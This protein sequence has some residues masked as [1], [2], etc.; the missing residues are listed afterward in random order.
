MNVAIA[1]VYNKTLR[2][3]SNGSISNGMAMNLASND[4]ERFIMASLFISYLVWGPL[5]AIVVL[6]IGI[7]ILGPAFAFGYVLLA[8][9]FPAQ[10]YLS[11]QFATFRHKIALITD[12]RVNLLSQAVSGVRV[13]KM[14]G[15]EKSFEQKIGY[16]RRA[17]MKQ[18]QRAH[19][20][21]AMNEAIFFC[22][23]VVIATF[24]LVIHVV[25][26][27][28]EITSGK[29]FTTISLLSLIQFTM[30]KFFAFGVM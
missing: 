24:V 30:G 1:A 26:L 22:C 12:K 29:V 15:W 21:K 17:E 10:F 14:S 20:L 9:I 7:N 5:E 25:A 13:M 4:V 3:P 11:K 2:L 23:S 16:L 18:I 6:V 19:R 27:D 28:G 8:L